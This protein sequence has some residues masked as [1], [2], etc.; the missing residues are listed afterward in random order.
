MPQ[1]KG[2]SILIVGQPAEAFELRRRLIASGA[3]VHVV[4]V[5]AASL[6]AQRKRIASAFIV[7]NFDW[8][9]QLL[10][11]EFTELGIVQIFLPPEAVKSQPS[12]PLLVSRKQQLVDRWR[13]CRDAEPVAARRYAGAV[14]PAE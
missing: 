6:F 8:R 2:S 13:F 1:I 3:T 9:T 11:D 12:A 10:R 7:A 5:A 14:Q 4:S